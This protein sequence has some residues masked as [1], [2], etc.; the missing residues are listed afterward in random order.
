M[1]GVNEVLIDTIEVTNVIGFPGVY[2]IVMRLTSVDRTQR[3]REA[4]R[5]LDVAPTGG[6]VDYNG[7]SNLS[8]QSYFNIE[9][10]L[11]KAELYPDLDLPTLEEMGKLGYRYVKY[12]SSNRLYPDPD[13]YIVYAYPYTSLIIKD[14][15][16]NVISKKILTDESEDEAIQDIQF[17]GS[18]GE[19]FVGKITNF[20]G[21]GEISNQNDIAK[22]YDEILETHMED[23]RKKIDTDTR[24][25]DTQKDVLKDAVEFNEII[26]Y[27][28][29][30]DVYDG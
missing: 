28:T 16:Q 5:R 21:I 25:N 24:L 30:C 14:M 3:Q 11:S 12:S 13:F 19:K 27:L 15:I 18:M 29:L 4:L 10:S 2:K 9:A 20:T 6:N 26:K 22:E 7:H 1:L 23:V 17:E 8:I